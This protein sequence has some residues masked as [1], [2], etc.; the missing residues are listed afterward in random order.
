MKP[1]EEQDTGQRE[2][3]LNL[4]LFISLA[5]FPTIS[6]NITHTHS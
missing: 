3:N 4:L 6:N 1:A 5:S 2:R